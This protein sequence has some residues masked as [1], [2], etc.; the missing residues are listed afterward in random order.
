MCLGQSASQSQTATQTS[1][2]HG[3]GIAQKRRAA[4]YIQMRFALSSTLSPELLDLL[5]C[6]FGCLSC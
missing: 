6:S 4:A 3:Q 5:S 2:V 1:R